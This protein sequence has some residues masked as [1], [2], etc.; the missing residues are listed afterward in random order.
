AG[1]HAIRNTREG[2]KAGALVLP[3]VGGAM[4]HLGRTVD[5][6]VKSLQ[7]R[8]ELTTGVDL[9]GQ[10]ATRCL[11]DTV[12]QTLGTNAKPRKILRPRRDHAPRQV[13]LCNGWRAQRCCTSADGC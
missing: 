3:V 6:S 11:A 10:T 13:A 1:C 8:H 4:A 12:S 5:N 7:R 2:R 9:D